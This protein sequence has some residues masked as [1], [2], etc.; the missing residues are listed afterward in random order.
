LPRV[1]HTPMWDDPELVARTLLDGSA[2]AATA[3]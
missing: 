1:G 2:V 3:A